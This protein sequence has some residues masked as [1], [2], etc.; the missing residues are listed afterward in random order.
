MENIRTDDLQINNLKLMQ[1]PNLFCF[2][3]DAVLLANFAKIKKNA[4][5]LDIGTGNG[6]IPVLLTAKTYAKK[7]YALEIQNESFELAIKNFELNGLSDIIEGVLGDINDTSPFENNYFDY[8][9]CNPPYK[10]IGNGIAN[11][12]DAVKIA[13]HEVLCTLDGIVKNASKFLKP[14]GKLA[15][16]HKPERMA[17]LIYTYKK[18]GIEAKRIQ[19]VY[20]RVGASPCLVLIEGTKGGKAELKFEKP[21]FIYDENGNYTAN[22]DKLYKKSKETEN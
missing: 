10:P 5:V 7:I 12:T 15:M 11:T 14:S 3:T 4:T 6:I 17:E 2:G 16:V 19:M 1:N 22:I 21:L 18:Y 20:S 8:I 9:T 13:R